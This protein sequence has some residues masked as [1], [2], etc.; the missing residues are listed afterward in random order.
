MAQLVE[1]VPYK[2]EGIGFNFPW[3]DGDILLT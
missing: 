2:P 1:A 3:G